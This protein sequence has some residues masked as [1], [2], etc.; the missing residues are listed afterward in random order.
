MDRQPRKI[1]AEPPAATSD[2]AAACFEAGLR[3]LRAGELAQAEQCGRD[4]LALDASHADSMHLMGMLCV[5]SQRYALAVDWF[6]VAIRENPKVAAYYF[7]LAKVLKRHDRA[8]EAL[9]CFDRGLALTPDFAEG[10]YGFGEA[11]QQQGRLDEALLG[12]EEARRLDPLHW[13]ATNA[14]ALLHFGQQR[15]REA[16]ERFARSAEIRPDAGAFR[17]EARSLLHLRR[18]EEA[19][20]ACERA[21]ELAPDHPDILGTRGLILQNLARHEEAL[22]WFD[23]AIALKPDFA[24]A[25]NDRGITLV[26]LRRFDEASA[27]Y[28]RA[29]AMAPDY[30]DA[31][32]NAA[33]LQLLLG[34]FANGFARREWG[35]KSRAVGFVDRRFTKPMWR[36]EQIA[37][38]T[39]LL[40][41]DEGM[42]DAIQFSRYAPLVVA[43]G[44][45][46]ILEVQDALQPLLSRLEGVSLCLARSAD[47]MPAFDLHCPLSSLPLVFKTRLETIPAPSGPPPSAA[48]MRA[49]QQRLGAHDRLRVGLVWSGNP[50]HG[51]DRNRSMPLRMMGPLLDVAARFVSLQKDV[52]DG[53]KASLHACTDIVDLTGHLADFAE[54]AALIA[55]LDLVITVDT[56]VAHLAGALGR[57]TWILLPYTP[58]YRWLLDRDDSPWYPSVRLFRQDESRDYAKVIARVRDELMPLVAAFEAEAQGAMISAARPVG[59]PGPR[60]AQPA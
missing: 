15:Y 14:S 13:Q 16:S 37:G 24:E 45:S 55:C 50:A 35:R 46:V 60:R 49:W 34:D 40:H 27:S 52:T 18:P 44:A 28:D 7:D 11:L 17:L 26:A 36:G 21:L 33:L 23:R 32:W 47:A 59:S 5:A 29:V 22:A 42:G 57:P 41:S 8:E 25:L 43:R 30:A 6:A 12:F 2:T 1:S 10:W 19:L 39:I 54:T 51:N 53:D 58:D 4:A 31:H 56:S 3:L 38:Q 9:V 48:C 20:Q